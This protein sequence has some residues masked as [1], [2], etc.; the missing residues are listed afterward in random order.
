MGEKEWIGEQWWE[1]MWWE[2]ERPRSD[3]TI[4]PFPIVTGVKDGWGS[5]C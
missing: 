2:K 3:V 4:G 1:M 5:D